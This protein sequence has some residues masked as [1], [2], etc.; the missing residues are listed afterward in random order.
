MDARIF[1]CLASI[2]RNEGVR[3]L[4]FGLPATVAGIIPFSSM[5]LATYDFLRRQL[6]GGVDAEGVSV[7]LAQSA[8]IGAL[9][10]IVAATSC[11]PFEVGGRR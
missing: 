3:A 11:F 2:G 9:A 6:T 10:G 4:Y 8:Q 1:S 7:S 5:K